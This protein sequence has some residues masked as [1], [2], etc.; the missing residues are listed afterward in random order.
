LFA[1]AGLLAVALVAWATAIASRRVG[2][3][4][5]IVDARTA[6]LVTAQ[7]LVEPAVTPGLADGRPAAVR[8]IARVVENDIRDESLVRVKIWR[9]DGTIL[10]SDEPRLQGQRYTLGRDEVG[11]LDDGRI[12]ADVG[13]LTKPENRYERPYGKLLEVYLPI[14]VPDS[15]ERLLFEAYYDFDRVSASANRIWRSFAPISFGALL[16]LE[17]VQV[18]IAYSL[19]RRLRQ[20]QREREGLLQAALDASDVERRRIASDL[21]DGVVQD[22]AGV[23]YGL[24]GKARQPDVDADDAELFEQ[25]AADVRA[26]IKSL[27]SLLVDIYPPNLHE[28]GLASALTDL[29]ATVEG[30]GVATTLDADA[31]HEPLP[32]AAA[33][34]LYRAAQEALR[35]VVTHAHAQHVSVRAASDN[36][37]ATVAITDDGVGF[38][39]DGAGTN[40]AG[41]HFGIT[42]LRALVGDAGGMIDVRSAPG[43]GTTVSVGVP[44]S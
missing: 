3:R 4:E 2:E 42:G 10:Y 38:V 44:L 21:H 12:E 7:G 9:R 1:V 33:A 36:T 8:R 34:L 40:V 28:E 26:S 23:A 19:A 24:A 29:L 31:L 30:R 41:G 35:N 37:R 5:A 39:P 18:P 27:R 6:T 17:L 43:A 11:A 15:D 22:L 16:A 25:S 20:R 32:E 14:R 13:D